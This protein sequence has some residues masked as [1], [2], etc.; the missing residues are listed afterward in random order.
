MKLSNLYPNNEDREQLLKSLSKLNYD[1]N[2]IIFKDLLKRRLSKA[3]K[4]NRI[5]RPPELEQSQGVAQFL[6][7]LLRLAETSEQELEKIQGEV[8]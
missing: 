7:D 4:R 1:S 3:D 2:F 5:A 6:D 8:R